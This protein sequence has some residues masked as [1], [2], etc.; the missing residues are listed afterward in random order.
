MD[1][2]FTLTSFVVALAILIA[3]HEFGHFWVAQ[4]LGVK[5][6]RFSI[7]FGMPLLRWQRDPDSTEYVLAAIPLGGYVRM[8]D[9]R[10]EEVPE[11]QLDR[12]FNRQPVWKR[13]AIVIAGPVFN[14]LFAILAYWAIFIVGDLGLK[15][16]IGAVAPQSIAADSGFQ[17]GDELLLIGEH[18]ARSWETAIFS[19]SIDALNG[20][21]LHVRV[22][23]AGGQERDRWL[24]GAAIAALA[25]A[26][27]LL[28]RLGLE[29]SRPQ[30]PA[31]IGELVPG[32]P[33]QQAGLAVGD[34]LIAADGV[35]IPSWQAWV[36]LVR[37]R[38]GQTIQLEVERVDGSFQRISITP[39]STELD[40]RQIGRIGAGVQMFDDLMD[41]YR[42]LVRYGPV[43]ALGQAVG[44]TLDMSLMMLRVMGRMLTGEASVK[45]LSGPITIAE[46][47][48][49]TASS[50]LDAFV[51]FLA[52][53]SISLGVLNLLPIPVLDGGHLLYFLVEWIKGSPVSEQI[54]LQGQ[55]IGFILL[56]GLMVLAFYADLS[57][58]LG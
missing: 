29:P 23:D 33:A 35:T 2:L 34:R 48:G 42:V 55:N 22:R 11:S 44:K 46:I 45:N 15:P 50:G 51:K 43:D 30:L 27:D 56:A 49:R 13:S 4:S 19:F 26:P 12:A 17:S 25:D 7:G 36:T 8:L 6:L 37:E 41:D 52:V 38:P 16:V 5:V 10:E 47:A 24:P 9:E 14:L 20:R 21:D 39:Q 32:E 31:V 58:L 57:R 1:L 28:D 3:V 40:G 53:V 18:P 54:Q